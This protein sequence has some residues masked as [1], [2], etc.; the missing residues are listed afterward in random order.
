MVVTAIGPQFFPGS[1]IDHW[2]WP[3]PF[4]L[5]E[6]L[7]GLLAAGTLIGAQVYRYRR[8]SPPLQRQQTK[9]VMFSLVTLLMGFVATAGAATQPIFHQPG[10]PAVL[11]SV[12]TLVVYGWVFMLFPIAIGI[13]VLRYRLW[14]IDP[15]IN[16]TLV[17]GVLTAS[18]IG[19]YVLMV[20][21]LG[22][23]FQTSGNLVTSLVATGVVAVLFQPLRERLQRGVNRVM[24]GQRDEP[25]AVLSRL[26]QRLEATLAPDAMLPTIVETVREALKIP[27]AALALKQ[28]ASM[29]V[30][31]AVGTPVEAPLRVPLIYQHETVGELLLAPRAPGEPF[32]PADH[33][34]LHDLARQ[35]GIAVHAVRLT[36]D[37]QQARQRLIT[38]REEERRRLQRD[39][40]DGVGP[41]LASLAQ[42]L[43]AARRLVP[44]QPDVAI[45]LLS[46]LKM[47]VKA[48]ITDIRRLVYAL[49]PPV[50]DEFGLV[51]AIR[52][53]AAQ[54]HQPDGLHVQV[55]APEML[56]PLP[57]AV[58]VA[59]YRIALEALTNVVRHAQAQQCHIR[60][61][62]S[63]GHLLCLEITDDGQGLPTDYRAGV[64]LTAIRERTAE[65]GGRC[66][67]APHQPRGT[68]VQVELPYPKE[69]E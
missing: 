62:C 33:R 23:L 10:V 40:H 54:Y 58:E 52:E 45:T 43:D 66:T 5:L 14:D 20:G 59:A 56:P 31:T 68:R 18:I 8:V 42:R 19:L 39:L 17:Y 6:L 69:K 36:T 38:T 51:S 53:H 7:L 4:N 22:A 3:S 48:T 24:Y 21:A 26:G 63:D 32:S 27:Y 50:L 12:A 15:I 64:G 35:A 37:L 57:A 30:A 1:F 2:R 55:E 28:D 13:A 60:L 11:F 49:R 16:R 41:T 44:D 29:A 67:V 25:Y 46:E 61:T 9:W 34:L 65:L 47:Q